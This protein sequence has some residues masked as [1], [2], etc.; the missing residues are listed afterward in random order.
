MKTKTISTGEVA[1]HLGVTT[2]Y[3]KKIIYERKLKAEKVGRD[4]RID[5]AAVDEYLRLRGVRQLETLDLRHGRLD[6]D[7]MKGRE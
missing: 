1:Q 4:W 7:S 2:A 3:V 5:P 6:W